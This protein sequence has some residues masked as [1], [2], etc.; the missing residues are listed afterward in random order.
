VRCAQGHLP[1]QGEG[2]LDIEERAT[3]TAAGTW[4]PPPSYPPPLVR[5]SGSTEGRA[6]ASL[7]AAIVGI[8]LGLPMGIPGMVLGTL[9]YFLGKSAV[10]RID[11]SQG[12]LG[13]RSAAV[14]GWVLGVAAMAIGSAVT[15]VWIVVVLV[16]TSQTP[17]G[18]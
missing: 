6:I 14:A 17:T 2:S 18:G 4:Y 13:G 1:P 7:I 15:L 11:G 16:A 9:A 8:L 10:S 5:S 12:A 3:D